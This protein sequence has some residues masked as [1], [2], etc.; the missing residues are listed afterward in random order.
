[1]TT[2]AQRSACYFF[3]VLACLCL[4][5]A[6]WGGWRFLNW[7]LIHDI[8]INVHNCR[9]AQMSCLSKS[10]RNCLDKRNWKVP[11]YMSIICIN[12][13]PSTS[14]VWKEQKFLFFNKLYH[15]FPWFFDIPATFRGWRVDPETHT[16]ENGIWLYKLSLQRKTN[17]IQNMTKNSTFWLLSTFYRRDVVKKI[18]IWHIFI[19]KQIPFCD[20]RV[21]V[22][23]IM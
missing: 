12:L 6:W 15:E 13:Y 9:L 19:V 22:C 16:H 20:A 1:M 10:L 14:V 5:A 17:T 2:F 3:Y 11:V 18:S 8:T 23:T 7:K 21:L 4:N